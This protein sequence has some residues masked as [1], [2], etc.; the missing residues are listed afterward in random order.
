MKICVLGLGYI[1]LP[2]ALLLANAGY[3]VYGYDI[4]EKKIESLKNKKLYFHEPGLQELFEKSSKNFNPVNELIKSNCYIISVP[5]PLDH[6]KKQ[7]DLTYFK[8]A[9]SEI[10]QSIDDESLIIVESTV[11]PGTCEKLIIKPSIK[12]GFIPEKNIFV[13]HCPE[14][15][16]PGNTIYEMINNDRIIGGYGPSSSNKA[17]KIYSSFVKGTIHETDLTTAETVKLM[18]NT[19]RDINIALANDFALI[20]EELGINVWDAIELANRHP[21]VNILY[22]GPGVGG[23]CLPIDPWFLTEVSEKGLIIKTARK[24]NDYMPEHIVSII[25]SILK[26]IDNPSVTLL[27]LSYKKNIDDTRE[28]PS[29]NIVNLLKSENINIKIFDPYFNNKSEFYNAIKDTDCLLLVTDHDW[30]K[31][32]DPIEIRDLMRNRYLID[33]RNLFDHRRWKSAGFQVFLL[34]A[35]LL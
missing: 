26:N 12:K 15:A 5:T 28:T 16:I 31:S 2:T 32:I 1:G 20:C 22:P 7:S 6:K 24:I 8:K 10:L 30:F 19:Y 33:T 3:T 34:G 14:R 25:K 4:D 9:I 35:G 21:R 11:P 17:K 23:H 29:K 27:G 18:E 13:A